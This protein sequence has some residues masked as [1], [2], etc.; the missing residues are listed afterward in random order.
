M[1][2]F[3]AEMPHFAELSYAVEQFLPERDYVTFGSLLSQFRLF[4]C[5]LSVTSMHPTQVV[6]PFG[7]ISSPLCMLAI[8]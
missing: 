4:V 6:E 3:Y 1:L 8:L 5:R 7:K 2:N